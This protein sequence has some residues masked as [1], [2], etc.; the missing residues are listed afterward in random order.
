MQKIIWVVVLTLLLC[1]ISASTWSAEKPIPYVVV[2]IKPL[3]SLVAGVMQGVAEPYLLV[4][5]G[6]SP[7]GYVLRPSEARAISQADLVI[8]I[9]HQL[10]SFLEKPL[11]T[12]GQ[13]APQLEL[14][15]TLESQLLPLRKGGRWDAHRHDDHAVAHHGH[16]ESEFNP[17][18]WLN[19]LLAKQIVTQIA[20]ALCEVD[21][22]HQI[23]YRKNA[24][25]LRQRLDALH[26]RLQNKLD[27]VKDIPYVVFHDAYQ[28]FEVAYGLNAVGS[29]T[30][31]PGRKPGVKR[32]GEI[33]GK[34]KQLN[35]RCVFSEPQ[36]MPQLVATI[37]EGTGARTGVLDPLGVNLTAGPESYF[38]LLDDLA[39][40]LVI[41]LR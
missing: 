19:P 20:D 22:A 27:P 23:T 11:L 6:A 3:D 21:P 8:W 41:E 30:V 29:V 5:G 7:H 17:H 16:A 31:D 40:N 32:I 25:Q 18:L 26:L 15:K 4:K 34:I 12:L 36:F 9:G 38:Q 28:Y 1:F 33:R 2:S 24:E 37:I 10:E 14:M 39:D 35:A 13:H